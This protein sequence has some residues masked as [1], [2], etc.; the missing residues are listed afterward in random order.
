MADFA[1]IK[2]YKGDRWGNLVY[3]GTSRTFNA[4]MAGAAKVTIAEVEKVV[5]LGALDPEAIVTPG[6][7][8]DR[9]VERPRE[10]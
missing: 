5:E 7:F 4:T 6:V 3:R 1:L 10:E 2:A 9:V 8:V